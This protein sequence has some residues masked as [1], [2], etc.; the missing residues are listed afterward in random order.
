MFDLLV[1]EATL[2]GAEPTTSVITLNELAIDV[3][4]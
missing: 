4:D 1:L 3:N 2:G